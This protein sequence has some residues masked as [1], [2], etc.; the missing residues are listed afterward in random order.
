MGTQAWSSSLFTEWSF[1]VDSVE[2]KDIAVSDLNHYWE[3]DQGGA[4]IWM[5][6]FLWCVV[7]FGKIGAWQE[8][9]ITNYWSESLH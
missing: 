8:A 1:A 6:E 9:K 5:P 7:Q 3:S 4:K 2:I